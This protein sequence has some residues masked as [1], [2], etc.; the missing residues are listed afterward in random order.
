[1]KSRRARFEEIATKRVQF[2]L[3]KLDNLGNCANTNN[4]EYDENDVKKMFN[5]IDAAV[6]HSKSKFNDGL[7]SKTATKFK[8]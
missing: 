8:F 1:M 4:Y 3:H 7:K 6:R 5:A 2:I